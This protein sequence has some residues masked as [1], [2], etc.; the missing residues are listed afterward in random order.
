MKRHKAI[1]LVLKNVGKND[2][3]ISSTGNISRE[4]F[5]IKDRP[6]V[7]YMLGSMG[8]ASSIGLGLAI[9]F[10]K[11]RIVVLEGDGSILMNMGSMATIGNH[12]PKNLVHVVLDNESYESCG[13]Q[14]SVSKTAN[15]D[16]IARDVGYQMVQVVG[17]E[18]ELKETLDDM[19]SSDQGARFVLVKV[20]KGRISDWIPRVQHTPEEIRTRFE[21]FI[22]KSKP[23]E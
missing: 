6:Q 9:C 22:K 5:I 12:A 13:G 17:S 18:R 8:L 10:P 19:K 21:E 15:L 4:V 23:F 3:V 14:P 20:E 2:L 7:F 11:K 16:E 1:E